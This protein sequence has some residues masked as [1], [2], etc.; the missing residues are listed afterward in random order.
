MPV[1]QPSRPYALATRAVRT[2]Q[3]QDL[4][5]LHSEGL[6][7][8]ASYVF[9]DAEDA[10]E[11]FAGRRPG[12]VYVRFGNPTTAAFEQRIAAM[13]GADGAVAVGSGMAAYTAVALGLLSAGDHVVLGDGMFGTT[14]RFFRA[15]MEKFGVRVSVADVRDLDQWRDAVRDETAMF[16]LETPTN[17]MMHVAD[18]RALAA[19]A[20]ERDVVLLVDNTLCTPVL[21]NPLALGADLV[22]HS[23]AKYIDGQGRC[24]GG[25]VAGRAD[26]LKPVSEVLRTAGPSPSA[27][28]SWV[29][30]K[31]LETLPIRM[32]EHS[33]NAT[34]LAE[35][36]EGHPA[37]EE[38]H[39][40]GLASHPQRALADSQQ[41]G[42]GGLLAFTVRGGR[43]EAWN[44]VDAL[45]LVSVTTNIGDTKSMIT[46]PATTTHG[47]MAPE[48]QARAGIGPN[49]LRLSVGLEDVEDLKADLD[50]A[51]R[52]AGGRSR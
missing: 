2:G 29:F 18:V 14:P 45:S 3:Y 7:L 24:G 52:A 19:L 5:D 37:V 9:A 27:F 11:Q 41:S 49:L 34:L 25:V 26:L 12:H 13:E 36:L 21:Q 35:W 10:A 51:L 39:Y 1:N 32:R 47:R 50:R 33:R 46:H 44:V 15:Y 23:A 48:E 17:P 4:S 38:V 30:L 31:S 22:V 20:A 6:A 8:T 16:V 43:R 28:N 40:T 42:H